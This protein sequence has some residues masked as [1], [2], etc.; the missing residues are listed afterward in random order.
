[1]GTLLRVQPTRHKTEYS[2]RGSVQT[3]AAERSRTVPVVERCQS[4]R[5]A[6]R[7]ASASHN[8]TTGMS[9]TSKRFGR[10]VHPAPEPF[11]S[12][13]TRAVLKTFGYS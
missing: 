2:R 11:S 3:K 1:M 9:F 6:V 5:L 7:F 4:Y 10:I 12:K 13:M 8:G